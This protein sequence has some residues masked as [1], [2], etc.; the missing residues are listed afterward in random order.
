MQAFGG[1]WTLAVNAPFPL[2]SKKM[3]SDV[4]RLLMECGVHCLTSNVII[5]LTRM[6]IERLLTANLSVA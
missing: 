6:S 2:S 1:N 4:E 5:Y 3:M